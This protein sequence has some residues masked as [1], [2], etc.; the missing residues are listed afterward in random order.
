[1]VSGA[2]L[3]SRIVGTKEFLFRIYLRPWP[4]VVS[5]AI[6]YSLF[7][8]RLQNSWDKG[9]PVQDLPTAMADRGVWCDL[10]QSVSAEAAG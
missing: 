4:I 3:Y 7:R 6:L 8:P 2:I 9:I 10:V 1:M 5:G